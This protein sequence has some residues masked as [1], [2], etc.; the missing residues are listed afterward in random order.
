M[1]E[2]ISCNQW[3]SLVKQFSRVFIA[4]F[5]VYC[6]KFRALRQNK[7]LTGGKKKRNV[8]LFQFLH[9][10]CPV[11]DTQ[12]MLNNTSAK[13]QTNENFKFIGAQQICR[14]GMIHRRFAVFTNRKRF[15]VE[16]L[17]GPW[18][19]ECSLAEKLR[20]WNK[21]AKGTQYTGIQYNMEK[22]LQLKG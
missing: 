13:K 5:H 7:H 1:G 21:T 12:I 4:T 18:I 10:N 8:F 20:L 15:T 14:N 2:W 19:L 22:F 9:S 16:C 3:W 17:L 6:S 11:S